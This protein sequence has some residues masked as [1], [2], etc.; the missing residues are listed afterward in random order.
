M[1]FWMLSNCRRVRVSGSLFEEP[2]G[3]YHATT[4]LNGADD[5][6]EVVVGEHNIGGRLSDVR[7]VETHSDTYICLLERRRVVDCG[8][9]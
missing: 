9:Q 1:N 8:R 6:R 5:G 2:E 7:P 4:L 3:T